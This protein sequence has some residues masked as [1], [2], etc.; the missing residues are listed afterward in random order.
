MSEHNQNS[1][2]SILKKPMTRRDVL[3]L[4]GTGGLGLLLGGSAV[5]GMFAAESHRKTEAAKVPSAS[6][7]QVPFY[8][9]HQAGIITPAQNFI[10][11]AAFDVTASGS[12]S[13]QKLFQSW[14]AAAAAMAEGKQVGEESSNHNL[15]PVDTGESVGLTPSRLTI[16][17]GAGPSLFDD[18]FGL[19]SK[20]PPAFKDLPSFN[21]E[22]LEPQW[23]GGDIGVQVCADDM[24]VAFHAVRNLARIARGK[25]VLRWVQEGFQRST[26]ADPTG[27]TPRNL[28]GFKDGT[29]NPDVNSAQDMN[30]VVWARGN[31]G[32][33]WMS[34][35]SYMAVRR[36]RMRI[37]VWDRSSLKDQEN[38]FGRYRASGAPLGAKNEF[39]PV[40]LSA[41]DEKGN[42]HIPA[43]SHVALA[44][45]DGSIQIL[46]R[47][48]SYSGGI[49]LKTGQLDAG[50]LFISYQRDLFK[51]FVPMQQKLAK[52]DRLNEYILHV[53]SAVFACFP[54]ASKGGYIGD[55]LF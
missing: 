22:Q 54:G 17:F 40:D 9:Q 48:Y 15:P 52:S 50:L 3:R 49:D 37:E 38:T 1:N 46:R 36:I 28:L 2:D 44:R 7:D 30:K 43:D 14:T 26:Q 41:K 33:A 51:Q 25:A 10:C 35:G 11:F 42:P 16:T 55:T 53:G 34:G 27:S 6:E 12:N 39:D 29:V 4:A 45:G 18:R 13:L 31:D 21:G 5:G 23:C 24:Q 20:R 8:G 47:S 19:A 32:A